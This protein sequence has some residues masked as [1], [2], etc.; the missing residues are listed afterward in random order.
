MDKY[1]ANKRIQKHYYRV[2]YSA[3]T[4]NNQL[5]VLHRIFEKAIEYELVEKNP[6]TRK[7]W[8]KNERTPEDC[9]NW[10]RPDEEAAAIATLQK[11]KETDPDTRL[12]ILVQLLTGIRFSELRALENKDID[13][14]TPGIWIRRSIAFTEVGT[15]KNK[16]ARFQVIP[17]ELATELKEW[18]LR[19]ES[20]LLFPGKKGGLLPNNTLNR[21]YTRLCDEAKIRR[22]TSHGARHTSGSSYALMG[23]GQ[24][25]IAQ[26]LGHRHVGT[27]DRY[28]HVAVASTQPLVEERWE[29]WKGVDR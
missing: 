8:M 3:K 29:R 23:V 9:E 24:R 19:K 14:N 7:A 11:W 25:M 13:F 15:P 20:Q 6:V 1:K 17:R 2:G 5:S 18:M 21:A 4:I 10:W 22:I 12:V 26:L 27:T 16:R 28:T